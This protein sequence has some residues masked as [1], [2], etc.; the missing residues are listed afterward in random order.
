MPDISEDR[1][2]GVI[3]VYKEGGT[4]FYLL[5]QHNAGHW[6]FPKGHAE[7]SETP[8]EAACRE[9]SEETGIDDG[10]ILRD[11]SFIERYSYSRNNERLNKTVEYFIGRVTN[12]AVSIQHEE[13]MAYRWADFAEAEATITFDEGKG[14]LRQVNQYLEMNSEI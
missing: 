2:Y 14:L 1:S 8:Y 13:I 9:F 4:L 6:A 12:R 10:H 5:I 3:A 7:G 11:K